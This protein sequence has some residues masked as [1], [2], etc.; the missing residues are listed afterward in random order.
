VGGNGSNRFSAAS[1]PI[2]DRAHLT[3][4][5][6]RPIPRT[7]DLMFI[8]KDADSRYVY[9]HADAARKR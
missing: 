3:T 1:R 8:Y 7:L 2:S 4:P 6:M 5:T 9:E